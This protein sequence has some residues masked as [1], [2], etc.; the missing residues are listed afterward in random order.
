MAGSSWCWNHD[1][2]RA[3]ER[4]RNA[5]HAAT[6]KHSKVV[7]E[8]REVRQLTRDLLEITFEDSVLG[9]RVRRHLQGIVQLLQTYARL[10]ELELA[11]GERPRPGDVSLPKDTKERVTEW[12]EGEEASVRERE[13]LVGELS[14][15]MAARGYDPTP[16]RQVMG[17]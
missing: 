17:G 15:A 4:R 16:I 14:Q 10:A 7:Q 2:A 9:S 12:A 13:E 3:E 6:A 11:A 8:I 1:P 5:S